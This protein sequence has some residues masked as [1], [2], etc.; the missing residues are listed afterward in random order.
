MNKT[1]INCIIWEIDIKEIKRSVPLIPSI[2][3][4]GN[5]E[6]L[7]LR[8][9]FEVLGDIVTLMLSKGVESHNTL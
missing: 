2:R 8:C 3:L 5:C 6:I 4:G 9:S 1:E 7:T